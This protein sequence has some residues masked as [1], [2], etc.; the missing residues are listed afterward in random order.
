MKVRYETRDSDGSIA[1][2]ALPGRGET[3]EVDGKP[4]KVAY[5]LEKNDGDIEAV[6]MLEEKGLSTTSTNWVR[7]L[8][9]GERPN[10]P[11]G[12]AR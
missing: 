10:V 1:V 3:I 9:A 2:D 7:R 4:C 8:H 11:I 5:V 12:N 6:L